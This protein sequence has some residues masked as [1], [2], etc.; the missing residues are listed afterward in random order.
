M[1]NSDAIP[2]YFKGEIIEF[3]CPCCKEIL[4]YHEEQTEE[5]MYCERD[6]VAFNMD[7]S[8]L[9]HFSRHN[10]DDSREDR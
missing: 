1:N 7:G 4:S 5:Y 6:G 10:E 9:G 3:A 2:Q 8:Y